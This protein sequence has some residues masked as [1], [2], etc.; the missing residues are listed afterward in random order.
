MAYSYMLDLALLMLYLCVINDH[1]DYYINAEQSTVQRKEMGSQNHKTILSTY[2]LAH[3]NLPVMCH[4][5]PNL[6]I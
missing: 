2:K 5:L 4:M 3:L 6:K 1:T